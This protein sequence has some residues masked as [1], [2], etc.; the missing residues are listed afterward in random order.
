MS[1]ASVTDVRVCIGAGIA[2]LLAA[3]MTGVTEV[4]R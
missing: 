2:A 1:R 4:N 3:A